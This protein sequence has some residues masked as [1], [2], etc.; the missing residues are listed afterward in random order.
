[1]ANDAGATFDFE[2][3]PLV[4]SAV[5]EGVDYQGDRDLDVS[6]FYGGGN[7][8]AGTY[9]IQIYIDGMLAGEAETLLR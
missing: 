3:D 8:T 7:I 6:I 5:R 2:G 9:K 4:Y 1:M